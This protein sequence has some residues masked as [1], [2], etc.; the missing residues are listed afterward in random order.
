MEMLFFIVVVVSGLALFS[1]LH[2]KKKQASSRNNYYYQR[3]M[4]NKLQTK[5]Y[6][7]ELKQIILA[8]SSA[9]KVFVK[10]EIKSLQL[11]IDELENDFDAYFPDTVM[12][13]LKRNNLNFKDKKQFDKVLVKQSEHIYYMEVGIENYNKMHKELSCISV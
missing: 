7:N 11:F 13:K 6:I 2:D 5:R 8:F 1:Y 12:K 3:F 4:R 9:E 10:D